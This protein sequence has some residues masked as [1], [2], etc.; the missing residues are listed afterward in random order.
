MCF[1]LG[2]YQVQLWASPGRTVQKHGELQLIRADSLH[3]RQGPMFLFLCFLF[4]IS[5]PSFDIITGILRMLSC[6]SLPIELEMAL[7][8]NIKLSHKTTWSSHNMERKNNIPD[9]LLKESHFKSICGVLAEGKGGTGIQAVMESNPTWQNNQH[10]PIQ[11]CFFKREKQRL[12]RQLL[13]SLFCQL[14]PSFFPPSFCFCPPCSDLLPC[15]IPVLAIHLVL[16]A[17]G[18]TLKLPIY[19]PACVL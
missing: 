6:P 2:Q 18:R 10:V 12:W 8:C 15:Y 14:T 9:E 16:P 4:K 13:A 17:R 5:T 19:I 1:A 7:A 3:I 11:M